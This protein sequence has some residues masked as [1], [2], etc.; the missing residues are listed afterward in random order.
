MELAFTLHARAAQ[1]T[2]FLL[3]STCV[4]RDTRS[5]HGISCISCNSAC[6]LKVN[7]STEKEEQEQ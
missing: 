4:P 5:V 3:T 1:F 6:K 2:P 7:R